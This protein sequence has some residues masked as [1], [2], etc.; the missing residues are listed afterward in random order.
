MLLCAASAIGLGVGAVPALGGIKTD[1]STGKAGAVS[2]KGPS[3]M[4][5]P[6][7][8]SLFNDNLFFSFSTF[9]LT[10]KET[11]TFTGPRSVTDI[12]ARVTGAAAR[13]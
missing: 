4:I 10:S 6:R 7:Y 5:D 3:Y 12:I 13:P 1:G 11:A 8:G 9:D 2:L